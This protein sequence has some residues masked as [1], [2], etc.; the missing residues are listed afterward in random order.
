MENHQ[1]SEEIQETLFE[2]EIL[3]SGISL[4]LGLAPD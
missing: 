2:K 4:S 1:G 3:S